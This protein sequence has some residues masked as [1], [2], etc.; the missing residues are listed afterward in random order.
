MGIIIGIIILIIIGSLLKSLLDDISEVVGPIIGAIAVIF[1]AV[2]FI[3]A[4]PDTMKKFG[5]GLLILIGIAAIAFGIYV[6]K[7]L[8]EERQEK[9]KKKAEQTVNTIKTEAK[10]YMRKNETTD[11]SRVSVF[12]EYCIGSRLKLVKKYL[13]IDPQSIVELA[14]RE[15]AQ[16]WIDDAHQKINDLSEEAA[17]NNN[18]TNPEII[19]NEISP[20]ITKEIKI[21]LSKTPES[22]IKND[23]CSMIRKALPYDLGYYILKNLSV[24][25]GGFT[26]SEAKSFCH[27]NGLN[28]NNTTLQS[29]ISL[30]EQNDIISK[31]PMGAN[32]FLY[33]SPKM[34]STTI[35]L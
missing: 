21:L 2:Y 25:D 17:C 12:I 23:V 15:E 6:L 14:C 3:I 19:F 35:E 13:H 16:K 10:A 11:I 30:L 8:H 7:T 28:Y 33:K 5:I 24:N 26:F 29:I 34:K 9:E 1:V 27:N 32:S 18:T 22:N 20:K 4:Y 31:I